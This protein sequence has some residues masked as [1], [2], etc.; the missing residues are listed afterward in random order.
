[1]AF[2][3]FKRDIDRAGNGFFLELLRRA[4]VDDQDLTGIEFFL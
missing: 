3:L 1:M 2:E 4:H